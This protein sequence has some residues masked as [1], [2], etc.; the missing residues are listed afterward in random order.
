MPFPIP[1]AAP[2]TIATRFSILHIINI[3]PTKVLILR[4][5]LIN[6]QNPLILKVI[7][8]IPKRSFLVMKQDNVVADPKIC[9]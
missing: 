9:L 5:S 2:A 6:K 1:E 8:K 3:T 7:N 4:S